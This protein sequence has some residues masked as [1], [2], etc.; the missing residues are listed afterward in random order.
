MS[1]STYFAG[2][3]CPPAATRGLIES[4]AHLDVGVAVVERSGEVLYQ[5]AS[6]RAL[7][8]EGDRTSVPEELLRRTFET[9]EGV[10]EEE[11]RQPR[12]GGRRTSV[13]WTVRPVRDA[14]GGIA[15]AAVSAAE[16][17]KDQEQVAYFQQ[18]LENS[19]DA[20]VGTDADFRV[21]VWSPAAERLYG[22]TPEDVFGR[23]AREVASFTGDQS[24]V[25]LEDELLE[26]G[27][28]H[29]VLTALRPDGRPVE[30]DVTVAGVRDASG[31]VVG[32]LGIHRDVTER[33]HTEREQ[34]RLAAIVRNSNEFIAIADMDGIASFV[35]DAG[36][37]MVRFG[38][39]D[40]TKTHVVDFF[41]PRDRNFVRDEVLPLIREEGRW[42]ALSELRMRDWSTDAAIPVL[43]DAFQI[44]DPRTGEPL[45]IATVTRDISERKRAEQE[46]EARARQQ[47]AI[48]SLGVRAL[49]QNGGT[50][51][52]IDAAVTL[53]SEIL[54]VRYAGVA[55]V[56]NGDEVV[57]RAGT[58][59]P[60]EAIG[61]TRER[62]GRA[63]FAGYTLLAGEPVVSCDVAGDERF[64]T[65]GILNTGTPKSGAGVVMPGRDEPFG[66]L[67]VFS[68]PA[69]AF[70]ADDVDFLQSVANV[71]AIAIERARTE[72]LVDE[73]RQDERRRLARSLHDEVL[74][75]LAVAVAG[76]EEHPHL[77]G[78][79]SAA[80]RRLRAAIYDLRLGDEQDRPLPELLRALVEVHRGLAD[81]Y[82]IALEIEDG[83]PAGALGATG[84]EVV[85][86]LG[87]ALTN[88]R[89]H[90]SARHVRVCVWGGP[91]RLCAEVTDDG[92]GTAADPP[93]LGASRHGIAGMHERAALIGGDLEIRSGAGAGTTVHL[94]VPLEGE[95]TGAETRVLLVEDHTAVRQ[96]L[97]TVLEREAGIRV[98]AQASTLAEARGKLADVD[99][100]VLDLGLPD[101]FG[102]DLIGELRAA[103]RH[104]Q[105]LVLSAAL[106]RTEI[107]RAV[108]RGAAGVLD[109]TA[110]L[111]EVV[112]AVKRLRAGETLLPPT[113]VTELLRLAREEELR[114]R[115][116]RVR[117]DEITE[118]EREVLQLLADGLNTQQI[119]ARL[120][121][122]TRTHRNHVA[123]I[124]QKLAVH[125]QLQAVL[126]GL[127]YDVVE[128]RNI[129]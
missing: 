3:N 71:L 4:V 123:N 127:R 31:T 46:S 26:S 87:E 37:R 53:V 9:A 129:P 100:A 1:N 36:R 92:H 62:A 81:G 45:A 63:T 80:G 51:P 8:G 79:I 61:T 59:W 94:E 47:A 106:D 66:V 10:V 2:E 50:G 60:P 88:V 25:S 20:I 49:A 128:M 109:K 85:R 126:V 102:A 119:S 99:V 95:A 30:V 111:Q 72:E 52:L 112:R 17:H 70:T 16:V 7:A 13:R 91:G 54:D 78:A 74:Q 24:R 55:E 84:I 118:R 105:A 35:N 104:S 125:S 90:A 124:L 43:F 107:A 97:A 116:M 89:R 73:A 67:T 64:A 65:S 101:G 21:T 18:L 40:V 44:D 5:N 48:A 86:I 120:H 117:L 58:G 110:T 121:I 83:A 23:F 39:R 76:A 6:M 108:D 27:R 38:D 122:S 33:R 96:A 22:Y 115:D 77:Q 12:P 113:E 103:N 28:S 42:P 41:A 114:E 32:Y 93:K 19:D 56:I 68:D 98:V 82:E 69:R 75:D 15:A 29:T 14:A 57:L 34:G 11:R